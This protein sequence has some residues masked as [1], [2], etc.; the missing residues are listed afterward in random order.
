MLEIE[1]PVR[2]GLS[3][4]GFIA[5]GLA[6]LLA[7]QSH[8]YSISGFLTGRDLGSSSFPFSGIPI[9]TDAAELAERSDLVVECS[10]HVGR[11]ARVATEVLSRAKPLVTLNAEFQVT[12]GAAFAHSNLITEAQGDQPGSLAALREE[13]LAMGFRPLVFAS[14]KGFLNH[15]PNLADMV[16]WAGKQGI[17]VAST[18]AFTDGTKVNIEQALVANGLSAEIATQGMIGPKAATIAEGGDALARIA[19]E[20]G[21]PLADFVLQ[22]GGRGE[23]FVVA[24]HPGQPEHLPYYKLGDGPF[25]VIERPYHL[26]HYEVPLTIER[27]MDGRPPLLNAGTSPRFSVAAIAKHDLPSG[28]RI[29]RAIGSFEF[30]GE[31]VAIVD[32]PEHLPIGMI[33]RCVLVR[34]LERGQ[35]ATWADVE[36]SDGFAV[37]L[38]QHIYVPSIPSMAV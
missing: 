35:I 29:D 17:S 28:T 16:Y 23:I 37:D 15:D 25:F 6:R 2:V 12:L 30:R 27:V 7:A 1:R 21:A 26:G 33:E 5:K 14:Q 18:V 8:R 13:A 20:R 22:P 34:P 31:A 3:G 38:A 19:L 11:G 32:H 36:L 10:G 24:E 9:F 4:T